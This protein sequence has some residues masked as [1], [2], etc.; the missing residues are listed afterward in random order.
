MLY[1][2]KPVSLE[3]ATDDKAKHLKLLR[4]NYEFYS[5][6]LLSFIDIFLYDKQKNKI[7][8][9]EFNLSIDSYKLKI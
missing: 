6:K 7:N 3:K 2:F 8:I 9:I 1:V 4:K 5:E